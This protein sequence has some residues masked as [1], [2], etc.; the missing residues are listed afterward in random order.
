MVL[1]FRRTTFDPLVGILNGGGVTFFFV[2]L[3]CCLALK[4][5]VGCT[6]QSNRFRGERRV[7]DNFDNQHHRSKYQSSRLNSNSPSCCPFILSLPV[8]LKTPL[9]DLPRI[10]TSRRPKHGKIW[11]NTV[12]TELWSS[13]YGHWYLANTVGRVELLEPYEMHRTRILVSVNIDA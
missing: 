12:P 4:R 7:L 9:Q 11:E 8:V 2:L 1:L 13:E 5:W 3:L 10:P 6:L